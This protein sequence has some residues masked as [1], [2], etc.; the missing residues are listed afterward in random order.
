M[1]TPLASALF[2]FA[3][4]L[5]TVS[6]LAAVLVA[7]LALLVQVIAFLVIAG[8]RGAEDAQRVATVPREFEW[9]PPGGNS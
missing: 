7:G 3:A 1:P 8:M 5:L 9:S 6:T 4:F 2:I